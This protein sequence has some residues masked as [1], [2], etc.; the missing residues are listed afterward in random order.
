MGYNFGTHFL[1][2]F[3]EISFQHNSGTFYFYIFRSTF[4]HSRFMPLRCFWKQ[5]KNVLPE[6]TKNVLRDLCVK[7]KSG[8][9]KR[10]LPDLSFLHKSGIHFYSFEFML[11]R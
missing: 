10:I 3:P 8:K 9:L 5:L 1:K 7:D 11:V 4:Y 2:V 6:I